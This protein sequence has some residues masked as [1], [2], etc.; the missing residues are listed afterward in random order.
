MSRWG[1]AMVSFAGL[2]RPKELLGEM[3]LEQVYTRPERLRSGTG[4]TLQHWAGR[5]AAKR[6]VLRLLDVAETAERLGQAEVL[7]RPTPLCS[8]SAVCLHGHPPGVRLSGALA[9]AAG[10][11]ERIR[12]S[13]SHTAACALAVAL[14]S[15]RLPEDDHPDGV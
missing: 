2:S 9:D 4:R 8:R 1:C 5:L 11:R 10:D 14:L 15:A 13:I 12:I 6:A 3:R 7:P